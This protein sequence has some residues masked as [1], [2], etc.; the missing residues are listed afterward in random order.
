MLCF[1]TDL[2]PELS[3]VCIYFISLGFY[4]HLNMVIGLSQ[5]QS[6]MTAEFRI[7]HTLVF[8]IIKFNFEIR[9]HFK[10]QFSI[11]DL[12]QRDKFEERVLSI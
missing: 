10:L 1:Q 6:I 12:S 9:G 5:R 7:S 2:Y 3:T 8:A 11:G 4:P